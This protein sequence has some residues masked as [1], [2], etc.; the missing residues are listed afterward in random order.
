MVWHQ[1]SFEGNHLSWHQG[2][3]WEVSGACSEV[4]SG[5]YCSLYFTLLCLIIV[6]IGTSWLPPFCNRCLDFCQ[7]PCI[8][9]M[10]CTSWEW[11][12]DAC[13]PPWCH[14]ASRGTLINIRISIYLYMLTLFFAVPHQHYHGEGFSR[15]AW[16][17]QHHQKGSHCQCQQCDCKWQADN[18]TQSIRQLVQ[19]GEPCLM[20]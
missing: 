12:W 11:R 6:L 14:W 9:S 4:T 7:S 17:V 5:M 15:D 13:I 20:L 10:D 16:V 3:V 19:T 8:C 1:S 2:F 18:S